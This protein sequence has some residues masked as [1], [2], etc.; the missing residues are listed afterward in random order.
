M[1]V[2]Q[3]TNLYPTLLNWSTANTYR[4]FRGSLPVL[5]T[6][7]CHATGDEDDRVCFDRVVDPVEMYFAGPGDDVVHLVV[8]V[9]VERSFL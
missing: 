1:G 5:R 4:S 3:V 2:I 7:W 8:S 9:V 6:K